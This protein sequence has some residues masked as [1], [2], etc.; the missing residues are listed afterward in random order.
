M[1]NAQIG[2][3]IQKLLDTLGSF[4]QLKLLHNYVACDCE[5]LAGNWC[6]RHGRVT[7]HRPCTQTLERIG[8]IP[9]K[10]EKSIHEMKAEN[11]PWLTILKL[12][13]NTNI[14]RSYESDVNATWMD[15]FDEF[16][17][18][19]PSYTDAFSEPFDELAERNFA[20]GRRWNPSAKRQ[21]RWERFTN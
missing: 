7:S 9:E 18:Q 1:N 8:R 15:A 6:A 11:L 19:L 10:S 14:W 13:C 21:N 5:L 17:T 12:S 16:W 2:N 3:T 20:G 4:S